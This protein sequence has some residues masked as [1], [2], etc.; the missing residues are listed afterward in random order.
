[1]A[2]AL[3]K[4]KPESELTASER[5]S[6]QAQMKKQASSNLSL[7]QRAQANLG[8][9]QPEWDAF[10]EQAYG[11]V[12]P[13]N[14]SAI[15][16]RESLKQ[17]P[18]MMKASPTFT[19]PSD[20]AQYQTSIGDVQNIL[21]SAMGWSSFGQLAEAAKLAAGRYK[22]VGIDYNQGVPKQ[23]VQ[24]TASELATQQARFA[25]ARPSTA[26]SFFDPTRIRT[27]G[28]QVVD[29]ATGKVLEQ[30]PRPITPET[31][32]SVKDIDI[33]G[34]VYDDG[35]AESVI[36]SVTQGAKTFQDYYKQFL[37]AETET[38]KKQRELSEKQVSG[39]L[40]AQ[41][42]ADEQLRKEQ[43]AKIP[44]MNLELED[45]VG[46][47][48]QLE[49]EFQA[50][51][52]AQEGKPQTMATIVGNIAQKKNMIASEMLLLQ[53]KGLALQGK[54]DAAQGNIDRAIDLKYKTLENADKLYTAQL[55][56][57]L[58]TLNREDTARANAMAQVV[59]DRENAREDAKQKEK[60][61]NSVL[62]SY[63]EAGGK[64]VT[65][66]KGITSAGSMT[67]ALM[68]YGANIPSAGTKGDYSIVSVNGEDM[69]FDKD[70]GTL[71]PI[72][73]TGSQSYFTDANG[74]SWN[75]EGW[76][77]DPTKAQ[78]MQSISDR[79]GKLTDANLE[80]KVKQYT[81]GITAD[82]IR[83][84]SAKTGVS[85]EALMTMV[86]QESIGGTSSLAKTDNNF[87]G[88]TWNNQD[89]IKPYGGVKGSARP[90]NEGGNYIK[91]PTKQSGLNAMG[92]LMANYGTV[93][94][95][96]QK[97]D[98]EVQSYVSRVNAG[99]LTDNQALNEISP[100]KKRALIE[101]LA[102]TPKPSDDAST[103][104]AKEKINEINSLKTSSALNDAVGTTWFDRDWGRFDISKVTGDY[105]EFVSGIK[106][107]VDQLT[108]DK[109]IDSKAQGATFGALSNEELRMLSNAASKI[110]NWAKL[111][112]NSNVKGFN[113]SEGLFKKELDRIKAFY[114]KDIERKGGNNYRTMSDGTVWQLNDDGT[115]TQ[116]N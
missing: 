15:Q 3:G 90:A 106:F 51:K 78:Q 116:I 52:L 74:V 29:K 99:A 19:D 55:N 63:Y 94:P 2:N 62:L 115:V 108:L 72:T 54:I 38:Q 95:E 66:I 73:I 61:I 96:G 21:G 65:V 28:G 34:T 92:A 44:E 32:E 13:T 109:L 58:P 17:L 5:A 69:I 22:N 4:F 1:M 82:M 93:V 27:A 105:Q 67:A 9:S 23:A 42:L 31:M 103:V 114:Q 85:W 53:G 76:A 56:A 10:V 70:T 46:Q 25:T 48:T 49:K 86:V 60:D 24:P 64:D 8:K 30:A 91:F 101:A 98:T 6:I 37:G 36:A 11:E 71:R 89:W 40:Q 18:T 97:V 102:T 79:I 12:R 88:L 35:T 110:N 43:E 59:A 104:V 7:L 83:N 26:P 84:T 87:G 100:K 41:K 80:A 20:R 112:R 81:P 57:L 107:L 111:D 113:I 77:T 39:I 16:W 14:Q 47:L 68:V 33:P 45:I 50:Y 75:L